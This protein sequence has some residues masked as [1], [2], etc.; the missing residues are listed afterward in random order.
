MIKSQMRD[1]TKMIFVENWEM[2]LTK[3]MKLGI[4]NEMCDYYNMLKY[5]RSSPDYNVATYMIIEGY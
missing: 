1:V 5:K 4:R 3:N 2:R